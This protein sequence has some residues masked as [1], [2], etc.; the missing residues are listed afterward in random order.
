MNG[1]AL[2][3]AI[4]EMERLAWDKVCA[5]AQGRTLEPEAAFRVGFRLACY[6]MIELDEEP[7]DED[8]VV[9][10]LVEPS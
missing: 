9:I 6:A 2:D 3:T 8:R 4:R 5:E 7:H 10:S 1:Q